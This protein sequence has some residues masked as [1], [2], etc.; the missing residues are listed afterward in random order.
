MT[1]KMAIGLLALLTFFCSRVYGQEYAFKV[2]ATKGES[3]IKMKDSWKLIKTGMELT[4][5]DIVKIKPNSYIGLV[6]KFGYPQ[7]L[8]ASGIYSINYL[9]KKHKNPFATPYVEYILSNEAKAHRLSATGAVIN[10]ENGDF[11]IQLPTGLNHFFNDSL[12]INWKAKIPGP[13][14]VSIK[15]MVDE[16]LF[17]KQ[18]SDTLVMLNMAQ[19][20][21]TTDLFFIEVTSTEIGHKRNKS[22]RFFEQLSSQKKVELDALLT[23]FATQYEKNSEVGLLLRASLF[24]QN[25]LFADAN[26]EYI[27][28]IK[29]YQT[30]D[31]IDL[32]NEFLRRTKLD[33]KNQ[34]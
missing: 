14:T 34:D 22:V 21:P 17:V 33:P 9:F 2:L 19:P 10:L 3:L 4:R 6:D 27:K 15:N 1:N 16:L 23:N 7:E 28:A 11:S 25:R 29:L 31:V 12:C 26:T 5:N 18:V 20:K 32:Y 24:E 13:Y 30:A 8:K